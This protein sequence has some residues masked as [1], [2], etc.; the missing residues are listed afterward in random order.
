[1]LEYVLSEMFFILQLNVKCFELFRKMSFCKSND[2]RVEQDLKA[3][4]ENAEKNHVVIKVNVA[5]SGLKCQ[6]HS[7]VKLI[8]LSVCCGSF[9]VNLPSHVNRPYMDT[10]IEYIQFNFNK[11]TVVHI[12]KG[13]NVIS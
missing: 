4:H 8:F 9:N 11:K 12:C 13:S 10:F 6:N 2:E 5:P 3:D 7:N 1:M